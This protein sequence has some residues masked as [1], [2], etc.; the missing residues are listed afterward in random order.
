MME[1]ITSQKGNQKL[2]YEGYLYTRKAMKM[3]RI[4]WQCSQ[5]K[6]FMC[7]ASMSIDLGI[8]NLIL[9]ASYRSVC[10]I[11]ALHAEMAVNPWQKLCVDLVTP[12]ILFEC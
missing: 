4:V 10:R 6:K 8:S 5:R 2:C 1:I 3:T 11:C 9:R 7:K 12:F